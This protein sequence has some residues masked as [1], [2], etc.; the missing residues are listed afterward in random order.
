MLI[1]KSVHVQAVKAKIALDQ[2][3]KARKT[4][5]KAVAIRKP[6]R[7]HSELSFAETKSRRVFKSQKGVGGLWAI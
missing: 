1:L 3:K 2:V 4:L 7:I 6:T 5:F